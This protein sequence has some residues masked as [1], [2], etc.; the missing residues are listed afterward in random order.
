MSSGEGCGAFGAEAPLNSY[1]TRIA[2]MT[3]FR[4]CFT[5]AIGLFALFAAPDAFAQRTA[6]AT[7]SRA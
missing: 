2:Q 7:T 6:T 5:I 1:Q 3:L 4:L